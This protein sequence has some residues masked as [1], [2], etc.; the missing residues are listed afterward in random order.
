MS[1]IIKDFK[2]LNELKEDFLNEIKLLH[3]FK[4]KLND[5]NV[6]IVTNDDKV[7]AFG[8]NN[9]GVLGFGHQNSVKELTINEELSNK[10]IIDFKNSFQHVIARTIDGKVYCWGYNGLF[11]LL[12]NGKKDYVIHKPRINQYLSDEKI[13]DIRCAVAHSLALS[14]KG[15]VFAW[16]YNEDGQIGNGKNGFYAHVSIPIKVNGFDNEKVVMISCGYWHS[17]ALTESG[18]VFGWGL[19]SDGQLGTGNTDI[20]SKPSMICFS[21]DVRIKKISCGNRHNLLLSCD[22]DIYLFGY[23]GSGQLGTESQVEKLLNPLKLRDSEKFIDIASHYYYEIS[24]AYSV[25]N[26]Y[27][28]WGK[29]RDEL[30][31]ELKET[32][33]KSF[34]EIFN[35][36]FGIT[37]RTIHRLDQCLQTLLILKERKYEKNFSELCTKFSSDFGIFC[38]ALESNSEKKFAILKMPLSKNQKERVCEEIRKFSKLNDKYVVKCFDVWIETNQPNGLIPKSK[39]L[40]LITHIQMELFY[41][42]L[43]Q[44]VNEL[45]SDINQNNLSVMT[46]IRYYTASQLFIEILECVDY[47]HKQSPPLIHGSLSTLCF[48]IIFSFNGRIL[49]LADIYGMKLHNIHGSHN[50]SSSD[51]KLDVHDLGLIAEEL[52]SVD[53]ER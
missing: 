8:L 14:S 22:G 46:L 13:I 51:E 31:K 23:N 27:Y 18:R 10:Q 52:F 40:S 38:K 48:L 43:K 15:E 21:I 50:N 34:D 36:H 35:S 26:K 9:W 2:I 28:I 19:N 45:N 4:D 11:G 42:S 17:L 25:H 37:Y 30:I 47:L 1:A 29:Y 5:R 49:K 44:A 3:I 20:S 6:L 32:E 16:G 7:F 12:G 41:C 53:N 39:E 24:I 33:F